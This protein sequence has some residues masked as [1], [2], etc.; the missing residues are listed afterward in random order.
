LRYKHIYAG[1]F[2]W[3]FLF[4]CFPPSILAEKKAITHVVQKGD[5]LWSI[6]EEYYHDPF[7]WPELWEMNRFITNPH[8]LKPGDVITLLEYGKEEAPIPVKQEAA[9]PAEKPSEL[10]Q[11]PVKPG[12]IRG[13]DASSFTNVEALGFLRRNPIE[14]WGR[15]FDLKTERVLIG[16]NDIVYAKI[17]KEGTKP[18]DA[19]TVYNISNPIE[20]P[21]SKEKCG[22]IHSFKGV[23]AVEELKEGY[24][25]GRI[26]KSFTTVRRDDLLMPYHPVSP[27]VLPVSYDGDLSAHVIAAKENLLLHGQYSVVYIDSGFEQGVRRGNIFEAI[28]ERESYPEKKQSVALPP[29]IL[30][31]ILVLAATKNTSAGVVFWSAKNFGNGVKIR[32]VLWQTPFK[33][34][35]GLPT[36]PIE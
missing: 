20:H 18:G 12:Q 30:A 8:W 14:P 6:C 15:I 9:I 21:L 11:E 13:I 2:V 7:L 26:Q 4:S 32:P 36:C 22:Y 16:E 1:L 10:P 27:C 25:V 17:Y 5:T 24:C 34:L 35:S 33:K 19:F 31:K 23:M 3:F 28:E 29:V